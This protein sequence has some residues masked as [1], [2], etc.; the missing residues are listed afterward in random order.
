[1]RKTL[2]IIGWV[3]L[4]LL[5]LLAGLLIYAFN[6]NF[7]EWK[8]YIESGLSERLQ[9]EVKINE[10]SFSL[11]EDSTLRLNGLHI[12]KTKTD[13]AQDKNPLRS[14]Q[15]DALEIAFQPWQ[16]LAMLAVFKSG[17]LSPH[18]LFQKM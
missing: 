16:L 2:K 17:L 1:M 18:L 9:R 10:F 12:T 7:S 3:L 5:I 6:S 15:I 13:D 14:L 4:S 8:P 11:G